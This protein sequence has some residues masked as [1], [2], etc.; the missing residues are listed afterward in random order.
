[1][2]DRFYLVSPHSNVG[3]NVSFH[4]IN[5]KGYTTNI[6]DSHIY[7]REE[8]QKLVDDKALR[9]SNQQEIP[10]SADHVDDLAVWHVDMQYLHPT[11]TY[12]T[13]KDAANEYVIVNYN[14]GY[15]GNDVAFVSNI[16]QSFDY[17][18]AM[19]FTEKEIRSLQVSGELTDKYKV[20]PKTHTDTIARRTFQEHNINRKTMI[21]GAGIKGVRQKRK[22]QSSGLVRMNCPTCGKIAWQ[23]NPYEFE[24][25][26]DPM[27]M[28]PNRTIF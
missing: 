6:D 26:S 3:S 24:S 28:R 21:Q 17:A 13:K 14:T 20:Y 19:I 2:K 4:S 8:I 10:L 5:N 23:R 18:K 15:D 27:C 9:T 7:T 11:D 1:M 25:C 12:P 16:S 22:R